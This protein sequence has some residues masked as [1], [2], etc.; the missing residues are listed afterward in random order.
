MLPTSVWTRQSWSVASSMASRPSRGSSANSVPSLTGRPFSV[1]DS[2]SSRQASSGVTGGSTGSRWS[3]SP[4]RGSSE[5][6]AGAFENGTGGA[7]S[8]TGGAGDGR[9]ASA[10]VTR[11]SGGAGKGRSASARVAQIGPGAGVVVGVRGLGTG[12]CRRVAGAI[13]GQRQQ[14]RGVVR[15]GARPPAAVRRALAR[16]ERQ[17]QPGAAVAQAAQRQRRAGR[18]QHLRAAVLRLVGT[19]AA[20]RAGASLH[21]APARQQEQAEP[22]PSA[23]QPGPSRRARQR[24][25]PA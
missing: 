5:R 14:A 9:S 2:T 20:G 18:P 3:G 1:T 10:S 25:C 21:G 17:G 4:W 8:A 11:A 7:A 6:A 22:E 16:G 15:V 13:A 19:L 24:R 12:G 23:R